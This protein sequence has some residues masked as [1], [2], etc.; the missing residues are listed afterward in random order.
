MISFLSSL[1]TFSTSNFFSLSNKLALYPFYIY[2]P[3]WQWKVSIIKRFVDGFVSLRYTKSR[4]NIRKKSILQPFPLWS[5][6]YNFV[7]VIMLWNLII[8]IL[9]TQINFLVPFYFTLRSYYFYKWNIN[10]CWFIL[11][12]E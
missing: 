5:L 8:N 6:D 2:V 7:N 9:A 11:L 10:I 3:L 4:K 1:F 12:W